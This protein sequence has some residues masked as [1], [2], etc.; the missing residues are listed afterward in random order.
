MCG[1]WL[2]SM[3]G[4]PR[5]HAV[6]H[7]LPGPAAGARRRPV[8]PAVAAPTP[9]PEE[10]ASSVVPGEGEDHERR[11]A[12]GEDDPGSQHEEVSI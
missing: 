9:L 3:A 8:S 11:H 12:A 10:S 7:R 5:P 2:W 4:Y 1:G 6:C